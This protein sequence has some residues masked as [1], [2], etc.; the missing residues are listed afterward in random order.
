MRYSIRWAISA[1]FLLLAF[2]LSTL[3]AQQAGADR[4]PTVAVLYFNNSSLVN[5]A[6]YEPLSKGIADVLITI[7]QRNANL[8]IVERDALQKIL[9][10]QDLATQKRVDVQTAARVGKILGA[11][12]VIVGGFIV[13]TKGTLELNGRSVNVE[14]SVVEHGETARGKSDDVLDII[15]KLGD[16]LS[17]ELKLGPIPAAA[18]TREEAQ[19]SAKPAVSRWAA[20]MIYSRAL[21]EDDKRNVGSAVALYQE[22]LD[23]TP[24]SFAGDQR[25]TAEARLK[26]LRAAGL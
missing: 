23:K 11:H 21:V 5:H 8:R 22:F 3:A 14:T 17:R 26:A 20:L 12:H 6:D 24:P 10:E 1:A 4:R 9:E 19:A 16:Q 13:D 18:P 15:Y 2:P 7:L 25:R